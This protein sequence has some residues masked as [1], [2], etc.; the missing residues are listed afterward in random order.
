VGKPG[1]KRP[2]G[3]SRRRW[4]DNIKIDLKEIG[5]YGMDCIGRAVTQAVSRWLPT[6]AARVRVRAACGFC[7]GQSSTGQVFSRVLRF[8]LQLLIS[9]T[10]QHSSS[11]II[12]GRYNRPISCRRTKCSVS[13]HPKQLYICLDFLKK[14]QK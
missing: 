6:A 13:P 5:W 8:P 4:V 12:R 7:G 3:R 9:P 2:L 1:G 10:A 11:S 14:K